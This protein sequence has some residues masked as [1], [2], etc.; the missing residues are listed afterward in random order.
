MRSSHLLR[1]E[2]LARDA[3]RPRRE[4]HSVELQGVVLSHR[5]TSS[6]RFARGSCA[7]A[8]FARIGE[9]QGEARCLQ[10]LGAAALVDR[11]AAGQLLRGS[12]EPLDR[13]EAAEV[14]LDQLER[15]KALRAGQPDTAL[16]RPLPG[17]SP[18]AC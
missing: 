1:A 6:R 8:T 10:H 3:R 7:R 9:R 18:P 4:A 15:A 5:R 14:A 12:P 2:E 16:A 17:K 13:R 11:R